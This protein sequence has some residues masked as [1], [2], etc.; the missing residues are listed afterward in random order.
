MFGHDILSLKIDMNVPR[1]RQSKQQ[2]FQKSNQ[3]STSK[4][5]WRYAQIKLKIPPLTDSTVVAKYQNVIFTFIATRGPS[6]LSDI[7]VDDVMLRPA[8]CQNLP[9]PGT[10]ASPD[11]IAA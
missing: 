4:V 5:D 7:A 8:E 10:T 2:I 3:Q 1:F 6:Y 11:Q 9:V